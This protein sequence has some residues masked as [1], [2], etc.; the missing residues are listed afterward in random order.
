MSKTH[1]LTLNIMLNS[2]CKKTLN[3]TPSFMVC[4]STD[5]LLTVS[6][7]L[8]SKSGQAP[9]F[10]GVFLQTLKKERDAYAFE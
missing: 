5:H 7:S 2:I 9:G 6:R 8:D 4:V 10:I 3:A 1:F